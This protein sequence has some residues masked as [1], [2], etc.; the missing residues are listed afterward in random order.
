MKIDADAC[1]RFVADFHKRN[2]QIEQARWGGELV[3]EPL[4]LL[5]DPDFWKRE[6]RL[7]PHSEAQGHEVMTLYQVYKDGEP[8]N[9][10]AEAQGRI[11]AQLIAWEH[12]MDCQPFDGLVTYLVLETDHG[13]LL[14]GDFVGICDE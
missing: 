11:D 13:Q 6:Y 10:K 8:V 7:R 5:A 1:R 3:G 12:R 14:L 4:A 9:D 2:P